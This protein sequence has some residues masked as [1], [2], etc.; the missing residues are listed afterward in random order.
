[1]ISLVGYEKALIDVSQFRS[2]FLRF[3]IHRGCSSSTFETCGELQLVS[4]SVRRIEFHVHMVMVILAVGRPLMYDHYV[5]KREAEEIVVC[6]DDLFECSRKV[7]F[8]LLCHVWQTL[9]VPLG[10]DM[11]LV[12][13]PSIEWEEAYCLFIL[14]DHSSPVCFLF[15]Q[16]SAEEALA[17]FLHVFSA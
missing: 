8:F 6:G 3:I 17:F 11:C 15:F 16:D 7:H 2:F 14:E 4:A 1:M 5:G 9:D 13:P 12:G 10:I